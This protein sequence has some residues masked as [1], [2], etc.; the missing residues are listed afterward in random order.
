MKKKIS[1][2][3]PNFNQGYFLESRIKHFLKQTYKPYEIIIID[4]C[5]TDNSNE[6]IKKIKLRY[7]KIKVLTNK[8]N[9]GV[10][11]S[12]NKGIKHAKG[13]YLYPCSVDDLNNNK[14]FFSTVELLEKYKNV[15]ICMTIPGFYYHNLKK[16]ISKSWEVPFKKKKFYNSDEILKYQTKKNFTIWGH[17]CLYK[18][19]FLKNNLFNKNFKWHHDW[20][21]L[22]KEAL[23]NG[24]AFVP[25]TFCYFRVGLNSYSSKINNKQRDK[26]IK[27]IMIHI[28]RKEKKNIRNKFVKSMVFQ[29]ILNNPFYFIRSKKTRVFITKSMIY[30]IFFNRLKKIMFGILSK[31]LRINIRM[32][33]YNNFYK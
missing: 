17:S 6:I 18:S 28:I 10:E 19:K 33:W 2:V 22:N 4:D 29:L 16:K 23:S 13:D 12:F 25:K 15:N 24:I 32:F 31:K 14:F 20:F 30:R 26:V 11:K 3:I 7:K 9:L 8:K 5:S 1:V 27:K 21:L